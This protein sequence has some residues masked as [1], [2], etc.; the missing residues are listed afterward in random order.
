MKD[1]GNVDDA[2]FR[3]LEDRVEI[4]SEALKGVVEIAAQ[5]K[6]DITSNKETDGKVEIQR[7]CDS[8]MRLKIE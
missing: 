4:L 8:I 6:S 7:F 2:R 5:L 1:Q 3:E